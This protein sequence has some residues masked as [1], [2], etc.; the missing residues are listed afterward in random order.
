MSECTPL[1][2]RTRSLS[3]LGDKKRNKSTVDEGWELVDDAEVAEQAANLSNWERD[4]GFRTENIHLYLSDLYLISAERERWR[5][6]TEG[7]DFREDPGSITHTEHEKAVHDH[8]SS[9]PNCEERRFIHSDQ[10]STSSATSI[11]TE[12]FQRNEPEGKS[13]KAKEGR[14]RNSDDVVKALLDYF[15]E[16]NRKNNRDTDEDLLCMITHENAPVELLKMA[17]RMP[18]PPDDLFSNSSSVNLR[19]PMAWK[20]LRRKF[21][22]DLEEPKDCQTLLKEQNNCCGG[23]GRK[24]DKIYERRARICYYYNKLFCQCC[25]R[26]AKSRIPARI[27]HQWNFKEYPVCDVAESFLRENESLPVYDVYAIEPGLTL[28]VKNLRKVRRTRLVISHLWQFIQLCPRSTDI[29]TKN[30]ILRTMFESIP[31]RFRRLDEVCV[32]SLLDFERIE[33]G[34]LLEMLEPLERRGIEHVV[35]CNICEQRGFLCQICMQPSDIIFPFQIDKISR[36]EGCGSLSH[37][38]CYNRWMKKYSILRCGRCERLRKK[39]FRLS[40]QQNDSSNSD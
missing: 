8:P 6:F 25:H 24:M 29:E 3:L 2:P 9:I 32:Y 21:I 7:I 37:K 26:G 35:S 13:D 4:A 14:D 5:R 38:K 27:L 10:P 11:E 17:N 33:N 31:P 12:V 30:G 20:P 16:R 23:C 36:C 15:D 28:K 40:H 22:F 19:G 1:R 34:N 39:R 18:I